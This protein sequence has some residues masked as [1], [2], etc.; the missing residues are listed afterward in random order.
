MNKRMILVI[1]I[2]II[3]VFY[4]LN[5]LYE[6]N[7]EISY[8]MAQTPATATNTS[9][10][11]NTS[12]LI[13][14]SVTT[15]TVTIIV[16]PLTKTLETTLTSVVNGTTTTEISTLLS[17]IFTLAPTYTYTDYKFISITETRPPTMEE[18]GAWISGGI[19]V[20]ILVGLTIAYGYYGRGVT[21][22][23]RRE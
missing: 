11:T 2:G 22:R 19:I 14:I 6:N 7:I 10:S 12:T 18:R 21:M 17:M 13:N 1:L 4:I 5:I 8:V 20:G 3:S 16:Y 23:R 9:I 15:A